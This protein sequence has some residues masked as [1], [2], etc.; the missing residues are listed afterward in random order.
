MEA[1]VEGHEFLGL[2]SKLLIR[3]FSFL[4][5]EPDF[6]AVGGIVRDYSSYFF[7]RWRKER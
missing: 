7:I 1:A 5:F 2:A 4:T 6:C 3:D